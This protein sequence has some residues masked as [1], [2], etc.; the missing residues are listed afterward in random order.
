M[1]KYLKE[2]KLSIKDAYYYGD[3]VDDLPVL[4]VVGNPVC[5]YPKAK[6]RNIAR[7]NG[8]RIIA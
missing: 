8:W 1:D 2:N 5:V 4:E 3:S 7:R 6:L